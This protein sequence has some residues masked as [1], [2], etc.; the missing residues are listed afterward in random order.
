MAWLLFFSA[1]PVRTSSLPLQETAPL[2]AVAFPWGSSVRI[3]GAAP[4]P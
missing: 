3:G 2:S 4:N 1:S